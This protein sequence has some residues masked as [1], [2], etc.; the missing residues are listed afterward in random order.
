MRPAVRRA[1]WALAA[2]AL[3]LALDAL[4]LEPRV[5]L[6][7]EEV[8]LPLGARELRLAHL[9]DLHV[10]S[11]ESGK[12][13]RLVRGVAAARPDVV[14]V[15]GDW[16]HDVRRGPGMARHSRAAAAVAAE[17]RR[18]APV[19]SVQGHSDYMGETVA[20]LS[21]AGVEWLSNEGRVLGGDGAGE[22][23][24][25]LGLNQQVWHDAGVPVPR[26]E[27]VRLDDGW[28]LGRR[29]DGPGNANHYLS[30]D[31]APAGLAD[32]GGAQAWSGYEATVA[33]RLDGAMDA[34]LAVHSGYA[35][36][37]DRFV[38]LG[39]GAP[40]GGEPGWGFRLLVNGSAPTAGAL[41][42]G[43]VPEPRRW[44]RLRVRTSVDSGALRV[45]ARAW[46]AGGPEPKRWQAWLEDRSPGRPRAGTVALWTQG[47]GGAAFRDLRVRAAD[48]RSLLAAP[49]AGPRRPPGWRDGARGTRLAL[50]LARS[51]RVAGS[52]PRLV[53]T[54]SPDVAR[55]AAA[56]GLDAV[57][58]GHTH[59][60]QV[61]IPGLGAL[62]T[63]T[64]LGRRYDR[65]LFLLPSTAGGG[66]RLYLN[67]GIGT[68]F[69][70]VRLA[71]PPGWAII[72][73]E[74]A[75]TSAAAPR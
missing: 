37:E 72:E 11:S 26:M 21:A 39:G 65:G 47:P 4:W 31:P 16:V 73:L 15:S 40:A 56:R 18:T 70:P 23:V 62:L 48:G 41:D 58:A 55:E 19:L 69:L 50:A 32:A 63:R 1:L 45:E 68:S 24:L 75:P 74:Q 64:R 14:L 8:R 34:G 36:G 25:L 52:T 20:A 51:P 7:R 71:N 35:R 13:R 67:P 44:Y 12:L 33:V 5:L 57:L 9:S 61:R 54:H 42:T 6:R 29:Q 22:S 66:T 3:L 53:L 10:A 43:L 60:G 2:L 46:P 27:P 38:R 30:W 49:L 17:L 28:A 59:G